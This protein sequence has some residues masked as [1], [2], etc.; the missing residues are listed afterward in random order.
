[1][2]VHFMRL[3]HYNPFHPGNTMT[4]MPS[5]FTG[6]GIWKAASVKPHSIENS[7]QASANTIPKR[8]DVINSYALSFRQP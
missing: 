1:M 8:L 7:K 3:K 5:F 4:K 2:A 6:L